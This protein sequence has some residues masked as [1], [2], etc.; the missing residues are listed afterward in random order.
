MRQTTDGRW[1]TTDTLTPG[2]TSGSGAA[3]G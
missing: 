1:L 2:E 3:N